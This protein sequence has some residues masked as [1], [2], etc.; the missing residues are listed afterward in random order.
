MQP[1]LDL[2]SL[3]VA[4][5]KTK[6]RWGSPADARVRVK[7]HLQGEEAVE[8]A[9]VEVRKDQHPSAQWEVLGYCDQVE[10]ARRMVDAWQQEQQ[11]SR[12]AEGATVRNDV[13]SLREQW[14]KL[15]GG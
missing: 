1:R 2:T 6:A 8:L 15:K 11:E 9:E 3:S 7:L 4:L 12:D 10:A 13:A 14:K 5:T